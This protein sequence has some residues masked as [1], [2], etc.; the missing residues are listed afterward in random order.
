MS[1]RALLI[2]FR[3]LAP[4]NV[5]Y[6]RATEMISSQF[7]ET[8]PAPTD[9]FARVDKIKE[10]ASK[11]EFEEFEPRIEKILDE[12][13]S[14]QIGQFQL[15]MGVRNGL[16]ALEDLDIEVI[17]ITDLGV[18]AAE[19]FLNEKELGHL[20]D[21]LVAREKIEEPL[22][23]A[24]RLNRAIS[25]Y[26]L[27]QEGC[28]YFCNRLVDLKLAKTVNFRT[29]V[30]PS[31]GERLDLMMIEKPL[32]MIMS[33]EEVPNLLSLEKA[34]S[35]KDKSLEG[36]SSTGIDTK[37]QDSNDGGS[38]DEGDSRFQ[39]NNQGSSET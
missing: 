33:L 16:Q 5:D 15:N 3:V 6:A 27:E 14:D 22:D 12:I 19:K 30:L 23:L 11:R 35:V 21:K 25:K 2:D 28:V 17:G 24:E 39:E 29:I 1:T 37:V 20:I 36:L 26:H 34:R 8:K 7:K 31:K 32:G 18:K 9:V 10:K 4:I 38:P 13:E